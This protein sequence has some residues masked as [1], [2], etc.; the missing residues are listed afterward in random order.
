IILNPLSGAQG[1]IQGMEGLALVLLLAGIIVMALRHNRLPL[2]IVYLLSLAAFAQ[3]SIA[4][5]VASPWSHLWWL[6]HAIFIA[7]FFLL[8]YGVVHAFNT[9]R[10]FSTVYSQAEVM[11]QLRKQQAHTQ[12][13]L[14]KLETANGRLAQQAATDWLT[15]V[16]N[17]RQLMKH[18]K[19]ELARAQ[20]NGTHLSLLC[21]DLD[22]FKTIN[23]VHGHQAGDK[24]LK[25]VASAIEEHLRPTDL[26]ARVGGE[27]F[28]VLL[29]DADIQQA[30]EIA[31][32]IRSIL[33]DLEIRLHD[34]VVRITV[35]VGCA[36]LNRDGED[37]D[38]LMRVGDQRLYE[39]KTLGRDRVETGDVG[40]Y[41]PG[42]DD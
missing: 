13:A 26:L 23:D 9:T 1:M 37:M 31:E 41:L 15:G 8:S 4:F 28:Q 11:E 24:V 10:S 30:G 27:E 29:P 20:R 21:L 36:Q 39:A 5:M 33:Q 25:H 7:G 19:R 12:E 32:R 17:R 34:R 35:S 40:L 2:M 42:H 16:A 38:S 3:A 14:T 6:A 18:A 22:H